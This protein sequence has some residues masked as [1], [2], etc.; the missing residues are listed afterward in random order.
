M[1][2]ATASPF[3]VPS[4]DS[5]TISSGVPA[6]EAKAGL[7]DVRFHVDAVVGADAQ[8]RRDTP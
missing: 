8:V 2:D 7:P 4:P 1:A 5:R 6:L 3:P